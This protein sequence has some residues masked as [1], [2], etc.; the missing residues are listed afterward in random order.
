MQRAAATGIPFQLRFASLKRDYQ[1]GQE[2]RS[3]NIATE[4]SCLLVRVLKGGYGL[5]CRIEYRAEHVPVYGML[6]LALGTSYL[7]ST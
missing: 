4:S 5:M 7:L 3:S 6:G 1:V 2:L